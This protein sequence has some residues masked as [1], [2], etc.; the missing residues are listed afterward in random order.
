MPTS[1]TLPQR[2]RQALAR[3][4][5]QLRTARN[6][7]VEQLAREASVPAA[8]V[9]QLEATGGGE[10]AEVARVAIVL[11]LLPAWSRT[12]AGIDLPRVTWPD[13]EVLLGHVADSILAAHLGL[14]REAVRLRRS[15]RGIPRC[16]PAQTR[17]ESVP[18][19]ALDALHTALPISAAAQ[20]LGVSSDA[21][22]RACVLHGRQHTQ[23]AP[24]W[25]KQLGTRVDSEVAKA[26]GVSISAVR[27]WRRRLNIA[28]YPYFGD[29]SAE[30]VQ[31]AREAMHRRH[32]RRR[33]AQLDDEQAV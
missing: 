13:V 7:T 20:A 4:V 8:S 17:A 23:E 22:R 30:I 15:S 14:S 29:R 27:R 12:S 31:R 6:L 32:A 10:P 3:T 28:P 18:V 19:E 26:N 9:E 2:K 24:V 5:Q 33:A 21:A 16:P 11:R 1:S 25:A